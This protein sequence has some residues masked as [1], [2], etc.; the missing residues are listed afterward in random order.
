[1]PVLDTPITTDSQNLQR[2][3]SQPLPS[4]LILHSDDVDK[5]LGD[6]LSK[7][8]KK[9]AGDLLIVRV[10]V[11][12]NPAV[13]NQYDQI[14]T[15]AMIALTAKGDEVVGTLDY[16]RPSD[17][18]GYAKHLVNGAPLP[19]KKEAPSAAN[20]P[21]AV[22]DKS[23]RKEVLKSKVPVLVDFWAAWCGPCHQIAPYIDQIAK[24]YGG[25][26]KVVKLDIDRNPVMQARYGV[27]S[28]PTMIVFEG[29]EPAARVT[30][31]N[32][33]ALRKTVERFAN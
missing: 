29:G 12:D 17:V 11:R 31:A 9:Y 21:I 14:A 8:A 16:V 10:D 30:G 15:P 20:H 28:I 7:T 6:A 13:H 3:I 5:P 4:L 32:P 18:R 2:V 24:D 25:K 19:S 26:I 27:Q 22:S 1:M 33:V 23:F